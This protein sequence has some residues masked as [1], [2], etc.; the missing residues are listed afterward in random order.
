[1]PGTFRDRKGYQWM[2]I[3]GLFLV[4]VVSWGI[5]FNSMSVFVTPIQEELGTTRSVMIINMLIR[6][7]A[8][9]AASLAAG[10]MVDR[11]GT[12]RIM[13]LASVILI[14]SFLALSFIRSVPQYLILS[15]FQVSAT[16][17]MGFIPVSVVVNSWFPGRNAGVMG[18]AYMGS[19]IGGM[20]FNYLGG[21]WISLYGWRNTVLIMGAIMAVVLIPVVFFILRMRSRS[22]VMI[23]QTG[24]EEG[25]TL[26]EALKTRTMWM[27]MLSFVIVAITLGGMVNNLTPAFQDLGYSLTDAALITSL[28]MV[29][30]SIGKILIGKIF[31]ITGLRVGS[32]LANLF[33]MLPLLGLIMGRSS[34]G[35]MAVILGFF[36]GGSFA[37]MSVPMIT[38]GL[39]GRKDFSRISGY[40]Q[41]AFNIGNVI[42]PLIM[43][44]LYSLTGSYRSAWILFTGLMCLN[45][46]IYFKYLPTRS[47]EKERFKVQT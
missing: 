26:E 7:A 9:V 41:A 25:M 39:F 44:P 24:S 22:H 27:I 32:L 2:I 40:K 37:S 18:L 28:V 16:I 13:R 31:N 34:F 6:G 11:F 36:L 46:V 10:S 21:R 14:L 45:F 29:S 5:V 38:D 43:S 33:L 20:L 8:S 3:A 35:V 23:G 30:M 17:F 4:L 12:L 15:F 42:A 47:A 19:G 1:M